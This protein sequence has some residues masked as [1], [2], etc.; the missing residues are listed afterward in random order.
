MTRILPAWA[1]AACLA[2]MLITSAAT[3]QLDKLREA[4]DKGVERGTVEPSV[5]RA[6]R[7]H[8]SPDTDRGVMT[9]EVVFDNVIA[10]QGAPDGQPWC[11]FEIFSAAAD[12][13]GNL[14]L[15]G[16]GQTTG[17][18][19]C[20]ASGGKFVF[21]LKVNQ[22]GELI[23]DAFEGDETNAVSD[24]DSVDVDLDGNVYSIFQDRTV[25]QQTEWFLT[26]HA[27]QSGVE[28]W[29]T[30]LPNYSGTDDN[31]GTVHVDED[32]NIYVIGFD[33]GPED[34]LAAVRVQR[35]RPDGVLLWDRVVDGPRFGLLR[36]SALDREGNIYVYYYVFDGQNNRVYRLAKVDPLGDVRWI[37]DT[38]DSNSNNS[39]QQ[40]TPT[41]PVLDLDCNSY[42]VTRPSGGQVGYRVKSYDPDGNERF[43]TYVARPALS[44]KTF[45]EVTRNGVF[46]VAYEDENDESR[47]DQFDMQT[48]AL[49]ASR[50]LDLV[51]GGVTAGPEDLAV[52]R[53]G[54]P[55]VLAELSTGPGVVVKLNRDDLPGDNVW[56]ESYPAI[57]QDRFNDLF[58]DF[59]D[60]VY[61]VGRRLFDPP[62]ANPLLNYGR[63][64]R[65]SQAYTSV[66]MIAKNSP[67]LQV[68]DLSIWTEGVGA[69]SAEQS[70]F[71][72]GPAQTSFA[73]SPTAGFS[74]PLVGDF[75]GQLNLSGNA[76]L[77]AGYSAVAS[78]GTT[79]INYPGELDIAIPGT[80]KLFAG[81]PLDIV[82]QFDPDPGSSLVADVTPELSATMVGNAGLTI[83]SNASLVAASSDIASFPLV[84][85]SV[86]W[87]GPI[88]GLGVEL[89]TGSPGDTR[90]FGDSQ[91]IIQGTVT[92]PQFASSGGFDP[93][94]GRALSTL[95]PEVFFELRGNLTN[96]ISTYQFGTPTI[97]NF[98]TGGSN[99]S[100]EAGVNI[101][102]AFAQLNLEANQTL[103]YEPS[104]Q[105]T[106]EFSPPVTVH[107]KSGTLSNQT[108]YT[109]PLIRDGATWDNTVTIS[110]T[111]G[112]LAATNNIVSIKPTASMP[113]TLENHT[114]IDIQPLVGWE[115]LAFSASAQAIG[116]TLLGF[117]EC[118]LCYSF[119]L[120]DDIPITL[121]K[122]EFAVAPATFE[123]DP[124]MFPVDPDGNP[125]VSALSRRSLDM[126]IYDQIDANPFELAA[127]VNAPPKRMLVYG[128]LLNSV[129]FPIEN[130]VMCLGGRVEA[131]P[132]TIL[133]SRTALVEVPNSMRLLP[134]V[135]RIWA[136]NAAGQAISDSVDLPIVMPRPNLGTAGPSLWASDPR[137]SNLAIDV[138]DG[139][140]PAGNPSF[141]ARRDYWAVL[142]DMWD[143]LNG[144][145]GGFFP[146][147]PDFDFTKAPPMPAVL[148]ERDE[149]AVAANRT[150]NWAFD[151]SLDDGVG[152]SDLTTLNGGSPTFVSGGVLP[153]LD[154]AIEIFSGDELAVPDGS[155]TDPG[156]GDFTIAAWFKRNTLTFRHMIFD[157]RNSG[158]GAEFFIDQGL[159][160]ISITSDGGGDGGFLA[161]DGTQINDLEW[162]HLAAVVDRDRT[163]GLRL[164]IDGVLVE[165]HDPT[166]L[167][168]SVSWPSSIVIGANTEGLIPLNGQLAD[169]VIHDRALTDGDVL[170]LANRTELSPMPRF[171]QPVENG[172]LYSL[173][174][175]GVYDE[176]DLINIRL[177]SPG[178]GGGVSD[179]FDLTV[180]APR[181]VINNLV[182]R[183]ILP[184]SGDT[185]ITVEGPLSVPY[186]AGF[187]QERF[188]NFN[189]SSVVL[190]DGIE[191]ETKYVTP[192]LLRAVVPAGLIAAETSASV[193]VF[194]P[195]NGT[196]YFDSFI[197]PA[198]E[199]V[200]SGGESNFI[201]I[202]VRYP[203]PVI[204][205]LMPAIASRSLI[206][207]CFDQPGEL[208]LQVAGEDIV[209][210]ATIL[211]NGI[212]RPTFV[213]SAAALSS[214]I[215]GVNDDR[216]NE[217][218]VY[219]M[220][221][222]G[223]LTA[224]GEL[225]VEVMNPEGYTSDAADLQVVDRATYEAI[226]GV[227]LPDQTMPGEPCDD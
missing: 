26:K 19:G 144:T 221:S 44:T 118:V 150:H 56:L 186:F 121:F 149:I 23:W 133:N 4:I 112:N 182:P 126:F 225:T 109:V 7:S 166:G 38:N 128:D 114:W 202:D 224:L 50:S 104:P 67:N 33:P 195:S 27:S 69:L 6:I 98:E 41:G 218:I 172:I 97:Y 146:L 189:P 148:I 65:I 61:L 171:V 13:E 227:T 100:F 159:L 32:G 101:A 84:N 17:P 18:G 73:I 91:N 193:S 105:V 21:Y 183:R 163:D 110:V 192:G 179:S 194:T 66:P 201:G 64:S 24:W 211:I 39:L 184:G 142:S 48:G 199:L 108:S 132:T 223:D 82:I 79:D 52:D 125:R 43:S 57:T 174:P 139:L 188:G 130:F 40:P 74:I 12:L 161:P 145:S 107:T 90:E 10:P 167:V 147:Y 136:E 156:D 34:L 111:S 87:A 213:E 36:D 200:E 137:T 164:Y 123:L 29:E 5:A 140:T 51:T 46:Y 95:K 11:F 16:E 198:G 203:R 88:P 226:Y 94:N 191:L 53:F 124:I 120:V 176:P 99:W 2:L 122:D 134:G 222:V 168:G 173:M 81:K 71:Q 219:T 115:T 14:I 103:Q 214:V 59:G 155:L 83:N 169:L 62:D 158:M 68:Q 190:L 30:S 162:H 47:V 96:Y 93:T 135:A 45:I 154:R 143:A 106:L 138:I 207:R 209:P 185:T 1:A 165:T 9:H 206:D 54:N 49:L 55:Y 37:Q 152:G 20:D 205:S 3:G 210:G 25:P 22:A 127:F 204:R 220:L 35:F 181:P 153:F 102:Q 151:S 216:P 131:L 42:V 217:A 58:I 215:A 141:I 92:R 177:A 160:R 60:N 76:T 113:G 77:G 117:D 170:R 116:E 157:G 8:L 129:K 85:T 187:E 78:G 212:A 72:I 75:G 63:V 208:R 70:F 28:L 119:P 15:L 197:P 31:A 196:Q 89:P 80:D 175:R 178:P 86:N 180:A